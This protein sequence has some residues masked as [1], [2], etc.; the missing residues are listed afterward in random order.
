MRFLLFNLWF[1]TASL[2]IGIVLWH[3]L[4]GFFPTLSF[5]AA[6]ALATI[7]LIA[8]FALYGLERPCGHST[9]LNRRWYWFTPIG[10]R[11]PVCGDEL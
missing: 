10:K 7:S 2:G 6:I 4:F 8:Y 9:V 3:V 11:C 1:I 5:P